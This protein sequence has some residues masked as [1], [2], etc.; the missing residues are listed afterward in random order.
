VETGGT[1]WKE[2]S[3]EREERIGGKVEKGE[4]GKGKGETGCYPSIHEGEN[5]ASASA[6]LSGYSS[7]ALTDSTYSVI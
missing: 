3:K 2:D 5:P 1:K 4:V 6:V 7:L